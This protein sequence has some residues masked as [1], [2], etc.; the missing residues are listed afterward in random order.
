MS[1]PGPAL[2]LEQPMPHTAQIVLLIAMSAM[3]LASIG[4]A[5]RESRRRGD[6]VLVFTVIGAGIAIFYEPLGDALVDVY[7]TEH[8]QISWIHAF[9]R[10]IPAFIGILYFWYLPV[11]SYVLLRAQKTGMTAKR[12]WSLWG[13][14]LTFAILFEMFV[15]SVGGK[16]WIYYGPQ[17]F[18]FFDVPVLTPFTY[19]SFCVGIGTG[20]CGLARVLPRRQQWL[21]VPAVPMLMTASHAATSMP[22]ALALH[23][24]S[25]SRVAIY[26]GAIGSALFAIA[27]AQIASLA[28]RKPWAVRSHDRQP[29]LAAN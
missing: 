17:A 3:A 21:I 4:Y 29:S 6:L 1:I 14:F 8:G 23:S 24:G 9:G 5:V 11:S 16:A 22:L 20:V 13:G 26:A 19:V 18:K 27:L 25:S 2:P 7:Y 15:T 12:F 10:S 28:V